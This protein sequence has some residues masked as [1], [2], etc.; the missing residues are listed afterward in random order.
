MGVDPLCQSDLFF[1]GQRLDGTDLP[2]V[3][4]QHLEGVVLDDPV[5]LLLR[6]LGL[7]AGEID[8]LLQHHRLRVIPGSPW[9]LLSGPL[10]WADG[11]NP[12][13]ETASPP[14]AGTKL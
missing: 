9:L 4:P 2:K 14:E 5:A 11:R 10:V 7:G 8:L 13:G 6:V 3:R 12:L 1:R